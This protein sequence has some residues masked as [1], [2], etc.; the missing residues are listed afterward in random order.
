M[1]CEP[2]ENR[3]E[4]AVAKRRAKVEG[5]IYKRKDGRWAGQYEVNTV[6]GTKR[7]YIYGKTRKDVAEKLRKV[8]ADRDKGLAFDEGNLSL[9]D[10]LNRWLND[11]VRDTVKAST[12]EGHRIMV[13]VHI[14][15]TLGY[16]KLKALTPLHIQ[17]LYRQKLDAGLSPSSVQC[18]HK[19]LHK[20]LKQALRWGL[21]PR[22]VSEAVDPPSFVRPVRNC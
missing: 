16:I 18:I 1:S 19:T 17:R 11:S 20:A 15:P 14:V 22:N 6:T 7:R 10:Y 2:P 3:K 9:G 4:A 8:L 13:R 21:V 12:L 5:G